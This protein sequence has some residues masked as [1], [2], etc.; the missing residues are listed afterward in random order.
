M[1]VLR[2]TIKIAEFY[3]STLNSAIID[4]KNNNLY[5]PYLIMNKTTALLVSSK[6]EEYKTGNPI[7]FEN[8]SNAAFIYGECRV[9]ID[10]S[11]A[12]GVVKLT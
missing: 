7:N 5:E 6:L 2:K 12:D 1:I 8:N 9:Y 3:P 10:D 4:F 11:L